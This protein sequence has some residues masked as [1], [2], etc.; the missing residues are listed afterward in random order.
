MSFRC[1]LDQE[2]QNPPGPRGWELIF[3]LLFDI[4][5]ERPKV[6]AIFGS[7]WLAM[8]SNEI[9]LDCLA[10]SGAPY[11]LPDETCAPPEK[12]SQHRKC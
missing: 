9:G 11:A 4:A 8:I 7:L 5:P 12:W 2:D 10:T 1:P 6:L 3:G